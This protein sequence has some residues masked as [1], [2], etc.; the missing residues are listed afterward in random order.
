MWAAAG[1]N[2]LVSV[3]WHTYNAVLCIHMSVSVR[4]I[5]IPLVMIAF[6]NE[7]LVTGGFSDATCSTT[8]LSNDQPLVKRRFCHL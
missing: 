2:V 8:V 5:I 6:R 3:F 1:N 7:P 4:A